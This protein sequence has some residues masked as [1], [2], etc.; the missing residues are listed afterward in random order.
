MVV[1]LS[2][3]IFAAFAVR[4]PSSFANTR[5]LTPASSAFRRVAFALRLC[6]RSLLDDRRRTESSAA[7]SAPCA[8]CVPTFSSSASESFA[9][10]ANPAAPAAFPAAPNAASFMVTRALRPNPMPD[11]CTIPFPSSKDSLDFPRIFLC[12][13]FSRSFFC[14]PRISS[15]ASERSAVS[16]TVSFRRDSFFLSLAA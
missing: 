11:P 15:F 12:S 5:R 10:A 8:A 13:W 14:F 2:A 3:S 6:L 1:F 4:V 9:W 7:I 16:S